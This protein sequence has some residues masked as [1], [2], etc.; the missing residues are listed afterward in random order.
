MG[1]GK[2]NGTVA[3]QQYVLTML[4]K[5]NLPQWGKTDPELGL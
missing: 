3:V 4:D 2:V 1:Y 5:F